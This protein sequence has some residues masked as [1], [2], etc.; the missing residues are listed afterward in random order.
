SSGPLH[1][2]AS[3]CLRQIAEVAA[4]AAAARLLVGTTFF[5]AR[6]LA[7]AFLT[8]AFIAFRSTLVARALLHEGVKLFAQFVDLTGQVSV[9]R[10]VSFLG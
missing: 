8:T 2:C 3:E 10:A 1:H 9:A 5:A 6:F 7:S 4:E